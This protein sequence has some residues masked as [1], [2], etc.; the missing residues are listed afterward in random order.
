VALFEERKRQYEAL[1]EKDEEGF[2]DTVE[3]A[4]Q[5]GA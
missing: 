2:K 4:E 5:T 1:A 3:M